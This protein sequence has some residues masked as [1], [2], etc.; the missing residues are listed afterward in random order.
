[1]RFFSLGVKRY[2]PKDCIKLFEKA[3]ESIK[4]IMPDVNVDFFWNDAIANSLKKAVVRGVK[5]KVA[6]WSLS[7]MGR[8]GILS[9]PG[10][11][12]FRLG[13]ERKRL[14]ASVDG[15]HAVVQ[16]RK[17]EIQKIDIGIIAPNTGSTLAH[18]IDTIFDEITLKKSP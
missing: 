16:R 8:V 11:E 12:I 6:Y 1:M 15:K 18:E 17:R 7:E 13:K 9:I 14:T 5:V 3:E 10:I 4:I 2:T